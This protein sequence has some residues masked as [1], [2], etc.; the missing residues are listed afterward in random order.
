MVWMYEFM[1]SY[2][3]LLFLLI[4]FV[5]IALAS[6]QIGVFFT[7]AGLPLIS[8]FLLTGIL[9]GPYVLGLISQETTAKLRFID[10]MSL[11]VIAFAAGSELYLK[12]LKNHFKN[13]AWVTVGLVVSTFT[14]GSL[15]VFMLSDFIPFMKTMPVASRIAVSILAGAI[16]VA[17]SPSSAMAIVNELRA[18]GPFTQTVLGVTMVTDV[19]VI[20][21]FAANSSVADALLTGLRPDLTIILLL[22]SEFTLSLIMG[23]TLAKAL[24][25]V[26]AGR[27]NG[28]AKICIT[29]LAGYFVFALSAAMR[30]F[31]HELMFVEVLLEPLLICMLGG[32]I[33]AN[34][35]SYRQEFSKILRKMEPVVYVAFFTLTGASLSFDVLAATWPVALIIFFV[36]M[37]SIFVGAFSVGV[38]AGAPMNHNR[39]AWMAYIT[40]AGVSLGLAKQVVVEF[41]D[42]GTALATVIISVIVLNQIIGPPMCKWAIR[43][44]GEAHPRADTPEFGGVRRAIIFGMEGQSAALARLLRSHG[45]QVKIASL[46]AHEAESSRAD[47]NQADFDLIPV[48]GLT[49]DVLKHIDAGDAEAIV[50]MLSDEENYRICEMAY[51]HFGTGSLIVRLNHRDNF[52]RFHKLGVLIVDPATAIVSLLD[53]FVRSPTAASLLLGMEANQKISEMELRNPNLH[54]LTLRDL[55]LPL[56]TLIISVSRRGHTLISH[57]FT[58]LEVGDLLTVVGSLKSLEEVALRF[59]INREHALLHLIET[60]SSSDLTGQPLATEV[61]EIF[62]ED[63]MVYKDRFDGFVEECMVIDLD[64]SVTTK[65]LFEMVA[66]EMSARMNVASALLFDL[67]MAREKESSTA[68]SPGIAIPHIIIEGTH[69]FGIL[70]ARCKEGIRFSETTP[71]VYAVF[72]LAGTKDE[73]NFHLRALA[74]IA[75]IVQSPHFE[76]KW[77]RAK[78]KKTLRDVILLADRKRP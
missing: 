13:I 46:E 12:E 9:V 72:V 31:T 47:I 37:A 11:A 60:V 39:I 66:D 14:L 53:Q 15:T 54:G 28:I 74:A 65:I 43:R 25:L 30:K 55:R 56:D 34:F 22:V 48:S 5:V 75:Q 68:I 69:Q 7:K 50:C 29:L 42:W 52:D 8:G 45:W 77:L 41:P 62:R 20:T 24:Q 4:G 49:L 35:S 2:I 21:L 59:D 36:R 63:N 58:R 16:L 76:N 23:Y 10:E 19:V 64:R 67:L 38:L 61:K 17:R 33:V 18:K 32:F 71:M 6:K 57:G 70:L 51:E 44:I 3:D 40:Q 26:L 1:A 78:N 27:M 73:R